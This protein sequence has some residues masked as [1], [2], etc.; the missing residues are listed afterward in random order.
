VVGARLGGVEG[1][2]PPAASACAQL[3]NSRR[4]PAK[5]WPGKTE[6]QHQAQE[7]AR[8]EHGEQEPAMSHGPTIAPVAGNGL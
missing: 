5:P 7:Q 1:P 3:A 6:R 8:A 2:G 4:S